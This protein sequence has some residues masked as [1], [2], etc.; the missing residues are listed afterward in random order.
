MMFIIKT[1]IWFHTPLNFFPSKNYYRAM[2]G[3]QVALSP[4]LDCKGFWMPLGSD[5][6]TPTLGGRGQLPLLPFSK[7]LII[8]VQKCL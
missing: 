3:I 2:E 4:L 6:G 5:P 7:D 8:L 1:K